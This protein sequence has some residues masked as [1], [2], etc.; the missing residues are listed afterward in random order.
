MQARTTNE[1]EMMDVDSGDESDGTTALKRVQ[2]QEQKHGARRG[3]GNASMQYFHDPVPVRDDKGQ[4]RWEFRCRHC[5]RYIFSVMIIQTWTCC[6]LYN[7]SVR[8]FICTVHG[9]K[10]TFDSEP[11]LPRLNNLVSHVTQC[12]KKN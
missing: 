2:E 11:T 1:S 7:F 4:P 12:S 6:L 3:P 8:S 9:N 10:I 5:S